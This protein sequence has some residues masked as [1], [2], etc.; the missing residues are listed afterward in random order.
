MSLNIIN[1]KRNQ[2]KLFPASLS[3]AVVV[4]V[5]VVMGLN[6]S[7]D[8]QTEWQTVVIVVV[9]AAVQKVGN[10]FVLYFNFVCP[11]LDSAPTGKPT[12]WVL[13]TKGNKST[14]YNES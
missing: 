5:V 3:V 13:K 11:L 12:L 1:S 2:L 6:H 14:F 10:M 8:R 4:V 9:V 7:T